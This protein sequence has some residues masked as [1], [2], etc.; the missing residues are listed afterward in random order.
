MKARKFY[1]T[2]IIALMVL[3][4]VAPLTLLVFTAV[5]ASAASQPQF[6][7]VEYARYNISNYRL[8][9]IVL[10]AVRFDFANSK[11]MPFIAGY[12]KP[13]SLWFWGYTLLK[14][15]TRPFRA[16]LSSGAVPWFTGLDT[17]S[18]ASIWT[19][20]K[21]I[22]DVVHDM[23]YTT[24][25]IIDHAGYAFFA[26][27][28]DSRWTT[29]Y[30]AS[31]T[32]YVVFGSTSDPSQEPPSLVVNY[33]IQMMDAHPD[34]KLMWVE[35]HYPDTV[36]HNWGGW[37]SANY[38]QAVMD[39]D[40]AVKQIY[41][42]LEKRGILN[43]TVILITTDHGGH[44]TTHGDV[45]EY[46]MRVWGLIHVP[47]EAI[48]GE[49][50]FASPIDLTAT[51][52]YLMGIPL[53]EY[54]T[55]ITLAG[56]AKTHYT[57][58]NLFGTASPDATPVALPNGTIVEAD[59]L[60]VGNGYY[61]LLFTLYNDTTYSHNH[62]AITFSYL[63][64]TPI[65]GHQFVG[66]AGGDGTN[67]T[68]SDL[69]N[70]DLPDR[71]NTLYTSTTNYYPT[72]FA[73]FNDPGALN[74]SGRV[75]TGSDFGEG[76]TSPSNDL[77]EKNLTIE[78]HGGVVVLKY[79]AKFKNA[80]FTSSYS[81]ETRV[82]AYII[83][84]VP[85]VI[86]E[87]NIT[88]LDSVDIT[89]LYPGI[90]GTTE[91]VYHGNNFALLDENGNIVSEVTS[92][93][94]ATSYDGYRGFVAFYKDSDTGHERA[95]R[96]YFLLE[97]D[98]GTPRAWIG[99]STLN[100]M[101]TGVTI[102]SGQ[103]FHY[104]VVDFSSF[105]KDDAPGIVKLAKYVWS[106]IKSYGP[107][108]L[109]KVFVKTSPLVAVR[110]GSESA[111]PVHVLADWGYDP[112]TRTVRAVVYAPS[113]A[114]SVIEIQAPHGA[115]AVES[116]SC[117][118]TSYTW[119]FDKSR[120][121][122]VVEALHS[123]AVEVNATFTTTEYSMPI[124]LRDISG[125]E[126]RDRVVLIELNSTNFEDWGLLSDVGEDIYVTDGSGNPLYIWIDIF[127]KYNQKAFIYVKLPYLPPNDYVTIY[128]HYGNINHTY[129]DYNN[130]AMVFDWLDDFETWEGWIEYGGG[131]ISQSNETVYHG[132]YSLKKD[133]NADPAGGYKPLGFTLN[134]TFVLEA[135]M[136]RSA[137][138]NGSADRI[139]V[140]NDSGN[141]YGILVDH[142]N[143]ELRI[144]VRSGW[145]P[146]TYAT[147][148]LS[149]DPEQEWY[150]ARFIWYSSGKMVA[151]VYDRS[152]NL[153]GRSE[154]TDTTY[155]VFVN[156]YVL[157]GST[158]YVDLTRIWQ[159]IDP[160]P[161]IIFNW[162]P[163]V[164]GNYMV[165]V[166]ITE[167][168]GTELSNYV[169]TIELNSASF[170][171]WSYLATYNGSDIYF[172]DENGDPLY[173]AFEYF[174]INER[175]ATIRVLIPYIPASDSTIIYMHFGTTNPYQ[176]YRVSLEQLL[177]MVAVF[178]ED[179]EGLSTGSLAGQDGY[180]SVSYG[181][182]YTSGGITVESG[183][184]YNGT[185]YVHL[186]STASEMVCIDVNL[187]LKGFELVYY[188]KYIATGNVLGV[189]VEDSNGNWVGAGVNIPNSHSAN[190]VYVTGA[191]TWNS[192][193]T[194]FT[195]P[196]DWMRVDVKFF[197]DTYMY[198]DVGGQVVTDI[199]VS[200]SLVDVKSICIL[201]RGEAAEAYID[202]IMLLPYVYPEP[203]I[204][205][206]ELMIAAVVPL[207]KE[208]IIYQ[209]NITYMPN[210]TQFT[211]SFTAT[212][213]T[214]AGYEVN[215]TTP[216]GWRV[217]ASPYEVNGTYYENN[218]SL[219]SEVTINLPYGGVHVENVT[220]LARINGTGS[221][222]QLWVKVLDE[223]NATVAEVTNA[224][225]GTNWTEVIINVN[226]TLSVL[227]LWINAAVVSTNTSSE[228]I[229]IKDV[230]VS[231]VYTSNIAPQAQREF[232]KENITVFANMSVE[233]GS[234]ELVNSSIITIKIID[235]LRFNTTT[236]PAEPVFV[237]YELIDT[238][239]Y[240]VYRIE[241]A[242][243]TGTYKLYMTMP[244]VL[245]GMAVKS[246]GIEITTALV[247]ELVEID[248]PEVANVTIEELGK[249][250]INVS[251]L[252][253][254]FTE[255]GTYTIL[256][257]VTKISEWRIGFW[258]VAISVIYGKFYVKPVDVDG[259]E[260]DY[261]TITFEL[262]NATTG[263]VV[264]TK[265]VAGLTD[266]SNLIAGNY[267]IRLR[268]KDVVLAEKSI[269]LTIHTHNSI[270]SL[271][272]VAKRLLSDYRGLAKHVVVNKG[273][274]LAG[275]VDIEPEFK[276][277]RLSIA[278]NGTGNFKL[279]IDYLGDLP[280]KV[281]VAGN[282]TGLKCFW[283]GNYLVV[284]GSLGS[285]GELN[286]TDL[287]RL[288][289]EFYDRL[290]N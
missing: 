237:G 90:R 65:T 94:T 117:N 276:Y 265:S 280:T 185:K 227:K 266:F 279:F 261:E 258:S 267:T 158:Y 177:Q 253:I 152:G 256:A 23:G 288:R 109:S 211:H 22:V 212:N 159:P 25:A 142:A 116:V 144:D 42:E 140:A 235:K 129:K 133:V 111:Y 249:E 74:G 45:I 197:N 157:G 87:V 219:V 21:T 163:G 233:L 282:V 31:W 83:P 131:V 114:W 96:G 180:Y 107:S 13:R 14:S 192:F 199:G 173:Y 18:R 271:S 196:T 203:A 218:A 32:D 59:H 16:M 209:H 136:Y 141:G 236:Y 4:L 66:Y 176:S 110:Y 229:A 80:G 193:G 272:V 123:S 165:P 247:N 38:T 188:I 169:V 64:A 113:G 171:Y 205:I 145:S 27:E 187:A 238:R 60:I 243:D 75:I 104:V 172:T 156:V 206:G 242:L 287:Y 8:L 220:L 70:T 255:P 49:Y 285:T 67:P 273:V 160:T 81:M 191:D 241:P 150:L 213:T 281:A 26:S 43:E 17:N 126:W 143:D 92:L 122:L 52:A 215:Y 207:L 112:A 50:E 170:P 202:S 61:T 19:G 68:R 289:L 89:G 254:R 24:I 257:N 225:I 40:A 127:D 76:I 162:V 155:N 58:L 54:A 79:Y 251:K 189:V 39:S 230:K 179:F 217:Y 222:R 120:R 194:E 184:A 84:G 174:N 259:A 34:W 20:L 147:V 275:I 245:K 290:G 264:R 154:Y 46:D 98:T 29:G 72:A 9:I 69:Q 200:F 86:Y 186:P 100:L 226:A 134:S 105:N 201:D 210:S 244:N 88:N 56:E 48:V 53:S 125:K 151:E 12:L 274:E 77:V 7:T 182:A 82:N 51:V 198:I 214:V 248:L 33:T 91:S 284:T 36:G 283:D 132:N 166:N 149:R 108:I 63:A 78:E 28:T 71:L 2:V 208:G 246:K 106:L 103:S 161:I 5:P 41:E 135:W 232:N 269:E 124:T 15:E 195:V 268:F 99:G 223:N 121:V 138:V 168:T 128:L 239:N 62:G 278:L 93:T 270:Q 190:P 240:S 37:G 44:G 252:Y 101:V 277:S 97:Y 55:G 262:V 11:Y 228:E 231:T 10:D 47:D 178:I 183:A 85:F 263:E 139:G 115:N 286:V 130:P 119:Y 1:P 175:K 6:T 30:K 146:T 164:K 73:L 221:Y 153:L 204:E 95:T 3:E 167:R 102:S 224:T 35:I 234:S 57:V 137:T 118:A 181:N 260:L 250:F 216:Y 148:S